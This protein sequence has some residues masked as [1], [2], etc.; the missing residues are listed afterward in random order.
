MRR[1]T[2]Y[3]QRKIWHARIWDAA[4]GK[5]RSRSLKIPVEGKKERRRKAEDAARELAAKLAAEEA[6]MAAR[7]PL[8]GTPLLD[9]TEAF[10][11]PDGEYAKEK[12][13]VEKEPISAHYLLTQ[14]QMVKNKME[15]FPEFRG[16][17][18]TGLTKPILRKW[19]LWMAERG[20]SGRMINQALLALR[21]PVR[22]AFA[23]DIIPVDP[24]AGGGEGGA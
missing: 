9:Y 17:T 13:L 24:F 8:A 16:L 1:P 12:A 5:Y 4:E 15:P 21:V 3:K 10:W 23:D 7:N 6:A 2:L 11:R 14:R 20:A 19:K 22:R 18:L